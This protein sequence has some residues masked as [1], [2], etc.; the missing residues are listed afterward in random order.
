MTLIVVLSLWSL[1]LIYTVFEREK[2]LWRD[3]FIY[4]F[5]KY[6]SVKL[7]IWIQMVYA[8]CLSICL[9]YYYRKK[10]SDDAIDISW[11]FKFKTSIFF[12]TYLHDFVISLT[13]RHVQEIDFYFLDV[14]ISFAALGIMIY[15][16][17]RSR[18][19]L[20]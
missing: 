5:F 19:N 6:H 18:Y 4:Y 14:S 1:P 7:H 20:N 2:G 12:A 17:I 13:L 15:S 16:S 8:E 3:L 9:L 11:A 10:T